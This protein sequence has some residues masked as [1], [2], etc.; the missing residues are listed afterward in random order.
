MAYQKVY[1]RIN[2]ENYPSDKTPL[3]EANLNKIDVAMNEVDNRVIS[4]DSTKFDKTEAST[5]IKNFELDKTTGVITITYISGATVTIDTMLEKLAINFDFDQTEQ[6]LVIT[7]DDGTVK[8]VN[9]KSLITQY[10]FTDTDTVAFSVDA[11]GNVSAIVKDGSIQERHL[12]P[13]Y[14]ADIRVESAKTEASVSF[15]EEYAI[16]AKSY[17]VG[18]TDTREDED[19]DNARYYYEESKRIHADFESAGTVVGVKGNAETNYRTGLVNLTP[20]NI[21]AVALGDST[22]IWLEDCTI[23]PPQ[24][25]HGKAKK[26]DIV[27][28]PVAGYVFTVINEGEG[29]D[30][31]E[32]EQIGSLKNLITGVKGNAETTYRTGDVNITPANIGAIP[33]TGGDV[34][35]DLKFINMKGIQWQ[36]SGYGDKFKIVPNF[37]G[38][39][40]QNKLL[41]QSAVGAA[42]TDPTLNTVVSISAKTGNA[43]FIGSVTAPALKGNLE[44]TLIELNRGGTLPDFGGFIDF[45]FGGDAA[46]YTSRIIEDAK[47]VLNVN[48]VKI[49][50][51]D[52]SVNALK[53]LINNTDI[54]NIF[55][56]ATENRIKTY[57]DPTQ[58]GKSL[59]DITA[60]PGTLPAQ[61][62]F[63]FAVYE[64]VRQSLY[65]KGLIPVNGTGVLEVVNVD[66]GFV[67]FTTDDTVWFSHSHGMNNAGSTMSTWRKLATSSDIDT[68]KTSFQAGCSKIATAIT[69]NGVSTATNASPDTMVVNI[70]SLATTYGRFYN[71]MKFMSE[72]G[73]GTDL[74]TNEAGDDI[75]VV[76]KG[77]TVTANFKLGTAMNKYTGTQNSDGTQFRPPIGQAIKQGSYNQLHAEYTGLNSDRNGQFI[78]V[79]TSRSLASPMKLAI[80]GVKCGMEIFSLTLKRTDTSAWVTKWVYVLVV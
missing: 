4:L 45:H 78:D 30:V 18:G 74:I 13:D 41:I 26:D 58:F 16:R 72:K 69:N 67:K 38:A 53:Y 21:G 29:W 43:E 25:L 22:K 11:D 64:A 79:W 1:S 36:E 61:S 57:Y 71:I 70:N 12:R 20:A 19:T 34:T 32:I 77:T 76:K 40:D 44:S 52:K 6:R 66:R 55:A 63:I 5:L 7:L 60:W 31:F 47:G 42:N 51:N 33:K 62:K 68:L 49:N 54:N 14:L 65:D 17:S 24:N 3:N 35:G 73:H 23:V 50:K 27:I 39:D 10:E 9:L 56:K 15:A 28:D 48:N 59:N 8:Y 80:T 46:D 37:S 75:I 2:W